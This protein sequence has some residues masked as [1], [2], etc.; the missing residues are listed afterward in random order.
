MSKKA[1]C[2]C[3]SSWASASD[4]SLEVTHSR[5]TLQP[6]AMSASRAAPTATLA[7]LLALLNKFL[8]S[9]PRGLRAPFGDGFSRLE[10]RVT[11][12]EEVDQPH[13]ELQEIRPRVPAN[14]NS[15]ELPEGARRAENRH[16]AHVPQGV[17]ERRD[18]A[19]F[20]Q[21]NHTLRQKPRCHEY[22]EGPCVLE[23]GPQVDPGPEGVDGIAETHSRENTRRRADGGLKRGGGARYAKDEEPRLDPLTQNHEEDEGGKRKAAAP[24]DSTIHVPP[25]VP[26]QSASLPAHPEHH[27]SQEANR[28]K[29]RTRLEDL[30]RRPL[31]LTHRSK[32]NSRKPQRDRNRRPNPIP[33]LPALLAIPYLGQIS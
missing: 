2:S 1:A 3:I 10:E 17:E 24:S 33:N 18:D 8:L 15:Q 20:L 29:Q 22:N 9:R 19:G 14:Q 16:L 28:E 5:S 27:V 12:G 25:D 11:D 4:G 23:E 26:R 7:R 6:V 30:L 21:T 13:R 32:Q 31:E